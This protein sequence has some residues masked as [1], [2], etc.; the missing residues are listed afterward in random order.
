[1]GTKDGE[2]IHSKSKVISTGPIRAAFRSQEVLRSAR[3][4]RWDPS[5]I[6]DS[7]KD[8]ETILLIDHGVLFDAHHTGHVPTSVAVIRSRPNGHQIIL[9]WKHVLVSFLD[10]LVCS[11][12]QAQRV[13]M[14]KLA[15]D[16]C[17]KQPTSTTR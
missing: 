7:R 1:M 5:L 8:F 9:G 4:I 15:Y 11:S 12:Y 13:Y 14:I 10:Q 6:W 3:F 2:K 17:P 16:G